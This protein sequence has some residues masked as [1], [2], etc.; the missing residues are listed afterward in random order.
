MKT[1][2]G[3][4]TV[5]ALTVEAG[6]GTT[7]GNAIYTSG[8]VNVGALTASSLALGSGGITAAGAIAGVSTLTMTGALSGGT[9]IS[10]SNTT[11]SSNFI[12]GAATA[13]N[14]IGGVILSNYTLQSGSLG[15]SSPPAPVS[16][17]SLVNGGSYNPTQIEFHNGAVNGGYRHFITTAHSGTADSTGNRIEFWT[18]NST[19]AAGSSG[20]SVSN[21]NILA[22]TSGKP[23]AF[24]GG[25]TVSGSVGINQIIPACGLDVNGAI[26]CSNGLHVQAYA[27]GYYNGAPTYGIG[28]STTVVNSAAAKAVQ[29]SGYYGLTFATGGAYPNAIS[30]DTSGRVG[31]NTVSQSYTLDVNGSCRIWNGTTGLL[32]TSGSTSWGTASDSNLK[33]VIAPITNATKSL[34]L[35]TPVYYSWKSDISN[36]R[37]IGV[38][39]QEIQQAVPEAV[40]QFPIDSN[41]YLSVRF[42]ELIPHLIT[43]VKEL[44]ARLSNVE[45][46]LART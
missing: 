26:A 13:S 5:D 45:A 14:S 11:T 33:N 15:A 21:L 3:T 35:V 22:L 43:A 32:A 4:A 1:P 9:T 46:Q 38:I 20:A 42:T 24:T 10:N 44:S 40:G 12:T 28:Y 29:I 7:P 2:S 17:L 18:N 30:V 36:T 16:G 19:T 23:A 39:A 31:I 6:A 37:Q 25:Q 27:N 8:K 34:E 41:D